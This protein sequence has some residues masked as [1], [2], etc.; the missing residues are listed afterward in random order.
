ML[1]LNLSSR[2]HNWVKAITVLAT[3]AFIV[4]IAAFL[5]QGIDMPLLFELPANYHG[6]VAVEHDNAHCPPTPRK[7]I[8]RVI[9][10]PSSGRACTS[11]ALLE[12]WTYM[13]YDY[14]APN[15]IRTTL[16]SSG[17]DEDRQVRADTPCRS[18]HEPC[19][20]FFVGTKEELDNSWAQAP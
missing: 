15:G 13:R 9:S 14:V 19:Y 16:R 18:G 6:W 8:Y 17:W 3:S 7:G 10:I 4:V 12:H 2:A 1:S 20:A 5:R 11:S